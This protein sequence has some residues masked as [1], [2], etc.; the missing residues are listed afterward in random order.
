MV[1]VSSQGLWRAYRFPI[2][3]LLAVAAGSILG[4]IF[5]P[6]VA[7]LKP[8]GDLFINL[9]FQIIVP[10]VF[11]SI[12]T[13][14]ARMSNMNRLGKIL[15][16]MLLVFVVTGAIASTLMIVLCKIMPPAQGLEVINLV[17]DADIEVM[18]FGDQAVKAISVTDFPLLISRSNMLPLILF[19]IFFGFVVSSFGEKTKKLVDIMEMLS[20]VFMKA[21]KYIMYYAPVGLFGYFAYL[22]GD[23]G[24]QLL[25]TYARTML[26]MYYPLCIFYFFAGLGFYAWVAGGA[27]GF[28]RFFKY[29]PTAAA[30]ALGT[31]SS[32]ATLP[33]NLTAAKNIGVPR[34]IRDI[35]LPVGATAHMDGSC[36][37]TI[38]K[39]ALMFGL[40]G[41]DFSGIDTYLTAIGAGVIC[42]VVMS[43]VPSGGLI[44]EVL[45]MN[46]YGFPMEYFPIIATIGFL[47]DPPATLINASGDT[48]ASMLVT[49]LVEGKDWIKK[50]LTANEE[51][52]E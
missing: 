16:Y 52:F 12:S 47:V 40:F 26:G 8:L 25:G 21:V 1:Q 37:S 51:E 24:P 49:R 50:K 7:F 2:I 41:K 15:G 20:E 42:G 43:A 30:T 10:V 14:V 29:I 11:F 27:E 4:L 39:I 18:K 38:I 22:V 17:A 28:R 3:L 5:G 48:S 35:V 19:S 23:M 31:Q 45:L 13:S 33:V 9:I 34:D 46:L 32:I 44:G 6:K 36:M